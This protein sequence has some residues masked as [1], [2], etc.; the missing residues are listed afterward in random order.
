MDLFLPYSAIA[1]IEEDER[2]ATQKR[3]EVLVDALQAEIDAAVVRMADV[4]TEDGGRRMTAAIFLVRANAL[5]R[6]VRAAIGCVTLQV[7]GLRSAFELVVVARFILV[8]AEGADEFRRRVNDSLSEDQKLADQIDS[9][10]GVPADFLLSIV[11]PDAKRPRDLYALATTL[12]RLD[13]RADS[14]RY[15][16]RACYRLVHKFVSNT[17]SHA[18]VSSIKRHS[19]REGDVLLIEPN[20]DP[21]FREPPV[22]LI[23]ALVRELALEVFESLQLSTA[24]L[25]DEIRRPTGQSI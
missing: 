7:L 21:I 2:A 19:R 25:P 13:R 6:E 3:A 14:D 15:S 11:D 23:A 5:L 8:A 18:N 9:P 16:L 12:D 20:P 1:D 22:L 4:A 10:M 24:A 17:G